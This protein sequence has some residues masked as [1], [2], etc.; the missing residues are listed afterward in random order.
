MESGWPWPRL[1][2][3]NERQGMFS[4]VPQSSLDLGRP[5]DERPEQWD[6]LLNFAAPRPTQDA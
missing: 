2:S 1:N 6:S 5:T 4:D 3:R